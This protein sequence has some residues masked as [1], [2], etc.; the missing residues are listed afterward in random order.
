MT[1]HAHNWCW[2]DTLPYRDEDRNEYIMDV[3]ICECGAGAS[4]KT[5]KHLFDQGLRITKLEL[6]PVLNADKN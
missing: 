1:D 2:K 5:P 4:I 6:I 3:Y